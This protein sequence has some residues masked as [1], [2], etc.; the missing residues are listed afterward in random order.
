MPSDDTLRIYKH[1]L[2]SQIGAL[3]KTV[4]VQVIGK[5]VPSLPRD[6]TLLGVLTCGVKAKCPFRPPPS[7]QASA[8]K[9]GSSESSR[10]L[11]HLKFAIFLLCRISTEESKCRVERSASRA[12]LLDTSKAVLLVSSRKISKI[13]AIFICAGTFFVDFA[14]GLF[15]PS[16]ARKRDR[17]KT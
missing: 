1:A 9:S 4:L 11:E 13:C 8:S 7:E 16:K 15:D 3:S 6:K 2:P 5:K 12:P 14:G 17:G 10:N